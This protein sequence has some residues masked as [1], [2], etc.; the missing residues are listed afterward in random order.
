MKADPKD[1][2]AAIL[3]A[4]TA[5]AGL[6]LVFSG[7]LLT[8]S[9]AAN[10]DLTSDRYLNKFRWFARAGAAPFS[11]CFVAGTFSFLWMLTPSSFSYDWSIY[12]VEYFCDY[13]VEQVFGSPKI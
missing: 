4:S 5:L 10:P 13:I 8:Q 3:S 2:V 7:F 1:V 11:A 12:W 6:V 9:M